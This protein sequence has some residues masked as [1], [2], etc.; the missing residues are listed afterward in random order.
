MD[1]SS[2]GEIGKGAG[3][4]I[5]GGVGL[6]ILTSLWG[7]LRGVSTQLVSR[8]I[9]N[10]QATG[11]QADAIQLYL[12]EQF[13]ASRFGP[14]HYTGWLLHVQPR[15]RT[16]LV[17]MEII[18]SAGR[19]FWKK[20]QPIWVSKK[21]DS[22]DIS[23]EEGVTSKDWETETIS[24]TFLRGMFDPDQ[25]IIDASEYYNQR[26]V[27]LDDEGETEHGRHYVKHVYGTAGKTMAQFHSK[28][29]SHGPASAG[30]TRACMHHRPLKW[31]MSQL[32]YENEPDKSAVGELALTDTA[33]EMVKE[34]RFWKDNEQWYRERNI[35]WRRGWLLHGEPGT[36]KTALIRA[37]AEDLDLPIFVYDLASLYNEELQQA[38]LSMLSEVPCMAVIEDIDAVFNKREN[39]TGREQGLTFDCLL[40]CL[41][42]IERS[43][44]LFVVVTTNKLDSIDD[45]LGRPNDDGDFQST[46]PGRID[47]T[48]YVGA[49]DYRARL[50]LASRILRDSTDLISQIV[51]DGDGDTAAQFQE[52]CSRV[53]LQQLWA[54][55]D[56]STDAKLP[57]Q[58]DADVSV[59][60]QVV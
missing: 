50:K 10:V 53:A 35:P 51:A 49:L 59:K 16:Q 11:F 6:T 18:G 55:R 1:F 14:R 20:W 28:S 43:N 42:G 47:R 19:L 33:L 4:V 9:I 5:G 48:L 25:L 45:A 7:Y 39:I 27:S 29:N 52:R 32:G 3:W 21:A 13:E 23:T 57:T 31:E 26:I 30:D 56:T 22:G 15:H 12:K 36:G 2:F 34:A 46:R 41:D 24:L 38:W 17:P 44:G 40:N 37:I 60:S 54:E 8:L 58:V